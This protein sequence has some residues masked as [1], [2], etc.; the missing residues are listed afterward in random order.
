MS[1]AEID[2]ANGLENSSHSGQGEQITRSGNCLSATHLSRKCHKS[3][4]ETEQIATSPWE[5]GSP[6]E[7]AE[8]TSLKTTRQLVFITQNNILPRN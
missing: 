1:N 2:T 8:T 4:D 6:W 7:Q 3:D 5:V